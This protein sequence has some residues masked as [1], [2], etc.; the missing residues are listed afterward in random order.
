MEEQLELFHKGQYW[1]TDYWFHEFGEGYGG[2][3]FDYVVGIL[4]P[5]DYPL[6]FIKEVTDK[7]CVSSDYQSQNVTFDYL[8]DLYKI[9]PI[10]GYISDCCSECGKSKS[11]ITTWYKRTGKYLNEKGEVI[12]IVE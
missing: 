2:C 6:K 8:F 9:S 11:Y 4:L 3:S 12:K 5:L 7:L 10:I 1:N